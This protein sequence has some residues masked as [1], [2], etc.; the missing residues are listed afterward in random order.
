VAHP[1]FFMASHLTTMSKMRMG[2]SALHPS[3]D[4]SEQALSPLA[5]GWQQV[6]SVGYVDGAAPG[7]ADCTVALY[8]WTFS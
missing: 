1:D 8:I 2:I 3:S 6:R 5:G 4:G 7:D